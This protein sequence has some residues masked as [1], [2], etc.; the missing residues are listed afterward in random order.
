MQTLPNG[1]KKIEASDNATIGN[2][3][4]NDELLDEK[5]GELNTHVADETVHITSV[6]RTS[7]NAKETPVGAQTK[8]DTHNTATS[9]HGA[10]SAATANRIPI[11]DA[12]G[13]FKVAAPAAADDVARLDSITK[14]QVGL[15]NVNNKAQLPLDGSEAMTGPFKTGP[16]AN[17][18]SNTGGW[19]LL[20]DNAYLHPT[21]GSFRYKSSHA[22]LGARGI[23]F[24]WSGIPYFFDMGSIASTADASFIPTLRKIWHKGIELDLE[25]GKRLILGAGG[26]L[27]DQDLPADKRTV[28]TVNN[29]I[30]SVLTEDGLAELFRADWAQSAPYFKGIEVALSPDSNATANTVVKRDGSGSIGV[31]DVT[32]GEGRFLRNSYIIKHA[33][34]WYIANSSNSAVLVT[35][36]E[37]GVLEVTGNTVYHAGNN[38][39]GKIV[40]L[41]HPPTPLWT[42]KFGIGAGTTYGVIGMDSATP[43]TR[44][45]ND[46]VLY[47]D[48]Q[49]FTGRSVFFEARFKTA[50]AGGT[51]VVGLYDADTGTQITNVTT[52]ADV[53]TRVRSGAIPL[54]SI[55]GKKVRIHMSK[56]STGGNCWMYYARLI[57]V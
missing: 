1:I 40:T 13:R 20:S 26:T 28:L 35:L 16:W 19:M 21:D 15:G 49:I 14:A 38:G 11:R 31:A 32:M 9:V 33:G 47:L 41:L 50:L 3:N 24:N 46:H 57:I 2:W 6:E 42:E 29:N 36:T 48:P 56:D 39:P 53:S 52:T 10:T 51:V 37:A 5:V 25:A 27:Y 54:S 12:N 7:W 44:D 34:N 8:V 45:F 17:V 18:S 55:S 22:S 23:L 4:R 43:T 30:L